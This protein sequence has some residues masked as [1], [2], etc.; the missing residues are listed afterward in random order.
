MRILPSYM[1]SLDGQQVTVQKISSGETPLH[2]GI[3]DARIWAEEVHHDLEQMRGEDYPIRLSDLYMDHPIRRNCLKGFP[4]FM[5]S[6]A[7]WER[8][9]A[10]WS[11]LEIAL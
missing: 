10:Q 3:Q 11:H 5:R 6:V 4:L 9:V 1:T 7:Y 2:Q 8:A